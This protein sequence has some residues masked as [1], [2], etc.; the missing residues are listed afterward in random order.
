MHELGMCEGVVATVER[1]AQGRAV[2]GVGVRAGA[3][4][5]VVPEA[6]A[7]SFEMVAAGSIADGAAVELTI[8]PGAAT[9]D[10]CGH[11]FSA[12]MPAASCPRCGSLSVTISG[13][14]EL[15]VEWVRYTHD[16]AV[17]TPQEGP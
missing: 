3:F 12:D 13:G 17:A 2:D 4:L 5:R 10:D 7:Q 1:R 16:Q 9:C 6:F 15:I 14:D 11:G 8:V